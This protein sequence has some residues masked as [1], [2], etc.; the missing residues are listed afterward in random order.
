MVSRNEW[1]S[2]QLTGREAYDYI[3]HA[4]P[5]NIQTTKR[6]F[7]TVIGPNGAPHVFNLYLL[8]G[9]ARKTDA[10]TNNE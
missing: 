6:T 5:V 9:R 3:V 4:V 10:S 8:L 1:A 2:I 7:G